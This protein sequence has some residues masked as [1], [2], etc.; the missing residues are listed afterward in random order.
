MSKLVAESLALIIFTV[1]GSTSYVAAGDPYQALSVLRIPKKS[2][3][4]ISL[5]Q[6]N[7]KTVRLSDYK[8]KVVLLGIF[9]VF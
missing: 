3:A 7:G 9:K 6:V 2:A 5:P 4:D 1:L 8:G